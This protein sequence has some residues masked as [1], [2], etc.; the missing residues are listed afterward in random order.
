MRVLLAAVPWLLVG[1]FD[2]PASM[3]I[4]RVI[5]TESA[6]PVEPELPPLWPDERVV[7]SPPRVQVP[8]G[9][10]RLRVYLDAGHGAKGNRGVASA[11]CEWEQDFTLR[12]ADHVARRLRAT[13]LFDVRVSR[14]GKGLVPYAQRVQEAERWKADAFLSLHA[15]S[16]SS[17]T[18]WSPPEVQ[19]L[20]VRSD[21]VPGFSIL[22]SDE[23]TE[24][25][26]AQRLVLAR[27]IATR[28]ADTG[29][30]PYSGIDYLGLYDGDVTPGVFV[31]RHPPGARI[32]VLRKPKIPSVIIETHHARDVREALRWREPE[33]LDGFADA[34][35]AALLDATGKRDR[36]WKR[37]SHAQ[38]TP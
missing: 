21:E 19:H 26:T 6:S 5:P 4:E 2:A 1:C 30:L 32:Y 31:S 28:M 22:W 7:L 24:T 12:V 15:D 10:R 38:E 11:F 8:A 3:L 29:F 27:S 34:L 20:C 16:R 35:A 23:G 33:T 37:K 25:L 9:G 17:G 14:K 36:Q 18:Y 13:G